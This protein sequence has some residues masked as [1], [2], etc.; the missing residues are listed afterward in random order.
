MPGREPMMVL[1][2]L[3][4]PPMIL[5]RESSPVAIRSESTPLGRSRSSITTSPIRWT[6]FDEPPAASLLALDAKSIRDF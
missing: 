6:S 2:P 5:S 3:R 4:R 1:P